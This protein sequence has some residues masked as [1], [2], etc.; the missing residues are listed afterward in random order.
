M[1]KVLLLFVFA[2][3]SS[4]LSA[5]FYLGGNVGYS[6]G[7][8]PRVNG[9]EIKVDNEALSSSNIYGS[10]GEGFSGAFKFGYYFNKHIGLELN[11]GYLDGAEQ[12]KA[13]VLIGIE[14]F[15]INNYIA[16]KTDAIAYSRL[17]RSTLSMVYKT[18][19]GFYGRF[20]FYIPIGGKTTVNTTDERIFLYPV[21]P[22]QSIPIQVSTSYK[23]E[24]HGEPTIGYAGAIGYYYGFSNGWQLFA[25]LEY[26]AL[27]IKSKDAEYIS[28]YQ[29]IKPYEIGNLPGFPVITTLED[30]G[31]GKHTKFVDTIRSTDNFPENPNFKKDEEVIEFKQSAPYDSFGINIGVVYKF[32]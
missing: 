30:L 4:N 11:V 31:E 8:T 17:F 23:Q 19:L 13:D 2:V 21:S 26:L 12:I 6:F 18:D 10:Y 20:G 28:Y 5:Q 29:E 15:A 22:E 32:N 24:I 3:I 16:I 7:A 14:D 1:K 9:K 25:E 27:A